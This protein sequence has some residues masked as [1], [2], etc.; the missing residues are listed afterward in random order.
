MISRILITGFVLGAGLPSWPAAAQSTPP[1]S[2]VAVTG[3][4]SRNDAAWTLTGASTPRTIPAAERSQRAADNVA[5]A[6]GQ[7]PGREQYRLLGRPMLEEFEIEAHQN[8][9][10]VVRGLLI[11]DAKEKRVNVVSLAMVAASCG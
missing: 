11:N 8:H 1:A 2:L 6:R 5:W 3:C 4:V 9:R 10:I 7:Q